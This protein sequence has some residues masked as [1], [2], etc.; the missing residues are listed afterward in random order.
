VDR[1]TG[2]PVALGARTWP[3]R[4]V[5]VDGTELFVREVP[6]VAPDAPPLVFVHGLG[7]S[8][9]NFTAI[10]LL[11]ADA[12][13]GVAPDLPG[14]G[15]T[16]PRTSPGGITEHAT[17]VESFLDQ[18]Y[19]EPVHLFGN[20]MGG[21]ISVLLAAKHPEL[22]RTLTL[23]SPAVPDFRPLTSRISDPRIPLAMLPVIGGKYRRQLA[24]VT[25]RER[26]EQ[27]INLCFADPAQVPEHRLKEAEDEFAAR[28]GLPWAGR[29]LMLTTMG[30]LRAWMVPPARSLWRLLPVIKAPTLVIWG[31]EDK[32]VTVR[33]APRTARLL[34][35][36]RLLVLPRTGHV[37]QIERPVTVARATLGLW[38]AADD[39]SW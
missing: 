20:S 34:P 13:R 23:V 4:T 1:S 12:G 19:D 32:L 28:A 6:D 24:A 27:L 3:G 10:G 11:L 7:G 29:S 2:D 33:K 5:S 38:E 39:G 25:A 26:A 15:R 21:A 17:L 22:V 30:L 18:E 8:S 31:T 14:F 37:A 35:R 16:P 9:L 36:G